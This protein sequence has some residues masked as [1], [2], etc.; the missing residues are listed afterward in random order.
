MR[1]DL[2]L[3][4]AASVTRVA[5]R[6]M[7]D[8]GCVWVNS[9]L[10]K[11]WH[12]MVRPGDVV[13]FEAEI[14]KKTA[15][16][17]YKTRLEIIFEGEDL[18]AVNK[19]AGMLT[20]PTKF[21]ETDTLVNAV[22]ELYPERSIHAVNRL[23]RG[24]S[25]I[26][27]I[28]L[29]PEKAGELSAMIMNKNIYKEYLCLVHG[30]IQKKGNIENYISKGGDGAKSRD[31]VNTGGNLAQTYYE[32]VKHFSG[33]TL[34]KVIIKTGRTHQIRAHM[35]YIKHPC[36][37]DPVYGDAELDK[38]L[39]GEAA[40]KRQ[41][42]HASLMDFKDEKGGGIEIKAGL[43]DDFVFILGYLKEKPGNE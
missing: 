2:Y 31:V 6:K 9:S 3:R 10:Q 5:A 4:K 33:A 32:P 38:R 13:G 22:K 12:R 30:K 15:L 39:F 35:K 29:T 7:I 42:L 37:G 26:V 41:M 18:I 34:L 43:P 24:T 40:P 25:G 17:P 11:K 36:A 21:R 20:H 8:E 27:L 14:R 19:P 23:D 28:A 1:L 16:M